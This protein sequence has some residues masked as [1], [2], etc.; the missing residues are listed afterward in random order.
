MLH[1]AVT[2]LLTGGIIPAFAG[3]TPPAFPEGFGFSMLKFNQCVR[4][5]KLFCFNISMAQL[6]SPALQ[7]LQSRFPDHA[8]LV[9]Y[10]LPCCGQGC[11]PTAADPLRQWEKP[12]VTF[13][14]S[15]PPAP[16]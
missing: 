1:T 14:L 9:R 12:A 2:I 4:K 11:F 3:G 7:A 8:L 15:A 5:R 13:L 16:P 10:H 6:R